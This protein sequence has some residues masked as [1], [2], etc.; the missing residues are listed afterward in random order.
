M[1]RT[2][3]LTYAAVTLR[4]WL[5]ALIPVLGDFGSAYALVPFLC[6]VPNLLVVEW[7][8]R[9]QPTDMASTS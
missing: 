8:L 9:R 4:L 3:A 6:W 1:L 2:F 7:L 5:F